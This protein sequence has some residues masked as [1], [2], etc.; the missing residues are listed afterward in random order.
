VHQHRGEDFAGAFG[1]QVVDDGGEGVALVEDV[2][3]HQH[4]APAQILGGA[5]APVEQG[6]FEGMAVAGGV[7]VGQLEERAGAAAAARPAPGRR[8]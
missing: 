2:V 1:L 5:H 4:G 6:A 8:S 3:E 7:Q